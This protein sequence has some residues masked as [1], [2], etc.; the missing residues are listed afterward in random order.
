MT[1]SSPKVWEVV[2][3]LSLTSFRVFDFR[4]AIQAGL[5]LI[6]KY[7]HAAPEPWF[8]FLA[9]LLLL[10]VP[11]GSKSYK[12]LDREA[13]TE[14]SLCPRRLR[15]PCSHTLQITNLLCTGLISSALSL[16]FPPVFCPEYRRRKEN[17]FRGNCLKMYSFVRKKGRKEIK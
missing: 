12:C 6:C 7:Q 10:S 15:R 5:P 17:I 11:A 2:G 1:V 8:V 13:L 3:L 9:L 16:G 14:P 4:L